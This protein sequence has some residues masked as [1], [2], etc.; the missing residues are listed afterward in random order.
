MWINDSP[1]L[2]MAYFQDEEKF[3]KFS[4]RSKKP[5]NLLELIQTPIDQ[6]KIHIIEEEKDE[7]NKQLSYFPNLKVETIVEVIEE[8]EIVEGDFVTI[9]VK[10]IRENLQDGQECRGIHS[11]KYPFVK[12]EKWILILANE[13]KN[14]VINLKYVSIFLIKLSLVIFLFY[15]IR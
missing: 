6:R 8:K 9:K 15:V 7:F 4:K 13:E 5:A 10:M 12:E 11:L 14:I 3:M 2:Q 1:F